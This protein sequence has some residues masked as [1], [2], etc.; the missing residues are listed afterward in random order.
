MENS[1][2]GGY[3]PVIM[4][5]SFLF[6]FPSNSRHDKIYTE[7]KTLLFQRSNDPHDAQNEGQKHA[8]LDNR[9]TEQAEIIDLTFTPS[10]GVN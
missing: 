4:N 5:N 6:P 9:T 8:H 7:H 1:Y 3:I 2:K 10:K